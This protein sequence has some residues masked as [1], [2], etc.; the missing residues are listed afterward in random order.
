MQELIAA[1]KLEGGQDNDL[2]VSCISDST[3]NIFKKR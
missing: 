3:T 2:L 1:I